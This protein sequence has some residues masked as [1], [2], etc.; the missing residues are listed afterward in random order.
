MKTKAIL[1]YIILISLPLHTC[2]LYG[3]DSLRK[4]ITFKQ[5]I[6]NG[7]SGEKE[8]KLTIRDSL[9]AINFEIKATVISGELTVELYDPHGEKYGNFSLAGS[10]N[11]AEK[12]NN[13]FIKGE[14]YT[15]EASGSLVRFVKYPSRGFWTAKIIMKNAAG[16]VQFNLNTGVTVLK[17][18]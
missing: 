11:I 16:V 6:L 7:E 5:I 9:I 4:S 3:Q 18:N 10:P 14:Y 8:V 13:E 12:Q 1:I 2:L 17:K 15:V